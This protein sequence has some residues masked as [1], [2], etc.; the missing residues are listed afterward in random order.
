MRPGLFTHTEEDRHSE[1]LR[2]GKPPLHPALVFVRLGELLLGERLRVSSH[3]R[4]DQKGRLAADQARELTR[5][6][7]QL[8]HS[9]HSSRAGTAPGGGRPWLGVPGTRDELRLD[10]E[11]RMAARLAA[12]WQADGP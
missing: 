3:R 11:P 6:H 8:G 12:R 9:C 5:A 10:V 7:G 1:S 2:K 4:V